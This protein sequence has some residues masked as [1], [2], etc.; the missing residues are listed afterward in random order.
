MY[1]SVGVQ[2][3]YILYQT[4]TRDSIECLFNSRKDRSRILV[5]LINIIM[6]IR[7]RMVYAKRNKNKITVLLHLRCGICVVFIHRWIQLIGFFKR[8]LKFL[9]FFLG[10]FLKFSFLFMYRIKS[11]PARNTRTIAF[12][13]ESTSSIE[14]SVHMS[15]QQNYIKHIIHS[16]YKACNTKFWFG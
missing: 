7:I 2:V 11:Y 12:E 10:G 8:I 1:S 3:N 15:I 6:R 5:L 9:D 16:S 14:N 13:L 4:Y